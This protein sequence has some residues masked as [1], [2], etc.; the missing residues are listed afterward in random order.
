MILYLS[1]TAAVLILAVFVNNRLKSGPGIVTRQQLYD[2]ILLAGMF[3]LLAGVSACRVNVGNDYGEYLQIFENLSQG[4]HVSSEIGFNA[5]VLSVQYFF[6]TGEVSARI[7]FAVFAFG[8]VFFFL[9]AIYDQSS[10]FWYSVFLFMMQGYYFSSMTSV[11]YYFV[12]SIALYAMKYA[13]QKRWGTFLFW[14]L[15][16]ALFH[17]TA[18]FVLPVYFAATWGW[19]K[20]HLLPIAGFCATLLLFPQVYR[21]LIFL[22]YPF[23]ENSLFDTGTTS[24]T[25][26]VKSL[27]VLVLCLL[28]YKQAIQGD[29]ANRFYFYLNIGALLLYICCSF[30]PVISRVGY[31][32]NISNLFLIPGVLQKIPDKKQK[33][34]FVT[35]TTAAFALYFA[36]FLHRA[37]EVD[38]RLLPYAD[39]IFH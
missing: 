26:I 24:V 17:K 34:F 8:T 2:Y 18:L 36:A 22:I 29:E 21:R 37:Y 9:R 39:W 27:G 31:Y 20:W 16:A 14:I 33:L 12:L 28:Y 15:F 3:L 19:K 4:R 1:L 38:I 13:Q 32:M 30:M 7:V 6:G 35:A 23:Y 10:W 11:R 25:N 5:V